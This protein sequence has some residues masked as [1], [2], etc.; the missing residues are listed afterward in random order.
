MRCGLE[1][2]IESVAKGVWQRECGIGSVAW[3]VA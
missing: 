2:G 1:C 3:S